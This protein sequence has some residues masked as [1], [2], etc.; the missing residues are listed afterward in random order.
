MIIMIV[1]VYTND[2][3]VNDYNYNNNN[4]NNN[5]DSDNDVFSFVLTFCTLSGS[6]G[7]E[8]SVTKLFQISV[9]HL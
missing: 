3:N 8:G 6:I 7:T 2:N 9:W 4:N 5:N 1:V